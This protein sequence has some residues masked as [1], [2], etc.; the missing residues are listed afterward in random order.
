MLFSQS[1][2]R[3]QLSGAIDTKFGRLSAICTEIDADGMGTLSL[4]INSTILED[5]SGNCSDDTTS[6]GWDFRVVQV[7]SDDLYVQLNTTWTAWAGNSE[8]IRIKENGAY[9]SVNLSIVYEFEVVSADNFGKIYIVSTETGMMDDDPSPEIWQCASVVDFER[10]SV[11]S[12]L[13]GTY[14]FELPKDI[15][16]HSVSFPEENSAN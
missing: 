12:K 1:P 2:A 16:D 8:I 9:A 5:I 4:Q 6:G 14:E 11:V 15:C 3:A 10:R 7:E 13:V